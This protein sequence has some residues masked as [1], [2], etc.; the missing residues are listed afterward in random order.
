MSFYTSTHQLPKMPGSIESGGKTLVQKKRLFQLN[1]V[2]LAKIKSTQ[3]ALK[4]SKGLQ[5]CVFRSNLS[6]ERYKKLN[7]TERRVKQIIYR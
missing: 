7:R 1:I 3:L 4:S 5:S 2:F 6:V